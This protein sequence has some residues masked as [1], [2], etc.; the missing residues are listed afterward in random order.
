MLQLD[1]LWRDGVEGVPVTQPENIV[2]T[3]VFTGQILL[4]LWDA[5]AARLTSTFWMMRA[6]LYS[7][8]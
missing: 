3:C 1:T 2:N 6:Q 8:A 7:V 5:N 4:C